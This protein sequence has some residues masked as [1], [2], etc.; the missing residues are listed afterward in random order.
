M[1]AIV[2]PRGSSAALVINLISHCLYVVSIPIGYFLSMFSVMLFDAPDSEQRWTIWAFYYALK[3]YP[4]MVVAA[5][6][7]A[8]IFYKKRFYKWTYPVNAVPVVV[9]IACAGL[10]VAFG[11]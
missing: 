5:I 3:V 11:D 1:S 4:F 6:V 2:R 8:W 9:I 10:M 7:L